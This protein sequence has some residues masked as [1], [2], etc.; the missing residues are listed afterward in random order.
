MTKEQTIKGV[1]RKNHYLQ[2]TPYKTTDLAIRTHWKPGL[3]TCATEGGA[4]LAPLVATVVLLF[5]QT[6]VKSWMRTGLW[7]L[8]TDHTRIIDISK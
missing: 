4:V 6:S 8:Q 3:N 2:Y 5:L 1:K 7:F